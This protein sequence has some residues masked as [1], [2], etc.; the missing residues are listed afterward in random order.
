MFSRANAD[1]LRQNLPRIEFLQSGTG[2][3]PNLSDQAT[4]LYTAYRKHYALDFSDAETSP[5]YHGV[6][7]RI[8]TLVSGSYELVCQQFLPTKSA[9]E[10]TAF[11]LHGY[12]DHAGLY[13]HLI[14]HL[15]EKNVAVIIADFPGHGLSS[16]A[17]ASINSFREY[18]NAFTDCLQEARK[19]GVAEPWVG[20]GQSTG[21]AII[22][23]SLLDK[24]LSQKF[25]FQHY[26]LLSPLLRPRHWSRSKYLFALVRWFVAATPRTFSNNSHDAEF[27]RFLR[28]ADQLQSQKL[29]RDWVLAMID[30]IRRFGKAAKLEQKL[31]IIQGSGD[32]TVDWEKNIPMILSKFPGSTVHWVDDARHHL[33][34]ESKSY[35]DQV[36]S[37]VS[38]ILQAE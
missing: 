11:I 26:I 6:T 2:S 29:P 38:K 18:S 9:P 35:R 30:Y 1:Q 10:K 23:D 33:V 12:F 15:L 34:N 19:Q 24:N 4:E 17:L 16:G 25:S 36:F 13:R 14:K 27:L 32:C 8:G 20:I 22:M 31:E 37:Q 21:A 7:C 28:Q 5:G 3:K